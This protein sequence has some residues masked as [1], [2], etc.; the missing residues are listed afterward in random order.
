MHTRVILSQVQAVI[1]FPSRH[2]AHRGKHP[3]RI[4]KKR[5][6]AKRESWAGSPVFSPRPESLRSYS[7]SGSG[8]QIYFPVLRERKVKH[9]NNSLTPSQLT[10]PFLVKHSH[11]KVHIPKPMR[12][13]NHRS[14][15]NY[16]RWTT[17]VR[18]IR[19]RFS[20]FAPSSPGTSENAARLFLWINAKGSL[21]CEIQA[22]RK[23]FNMFHVANMGIETPH[24]FPNKKSIGTSQLRSIRSGGAVVER[25]MSTTEGKVRCLRIIEKR[26]FELSTSKGNGVLKE[27]C[28]HRG[29]EG[30]DELPYFT[31][32]H[33]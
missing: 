13:F 19:A 6:G 18:T 26:D 29:S 12:K 25:E 30:D 28:W 22:V 15:I 3:V 23:E 17:K 24:L 21:K 27:A 4:W 31:E 14:Y 1:V 9:S 5:R 8:N 11:T 33:N 32:N 16:I 2:F 20:R 7:H 10:P